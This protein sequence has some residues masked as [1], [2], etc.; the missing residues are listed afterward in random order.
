[1]GTLWDPVD[2]SRYPT[3]SLYGHCMANLWVIYGHFMGPCGQVEIPPPCSC[4]GNIWVID[5]QCMGN[6]WESHRLPINCPQITHTLPIQGKGGGISTCPQG[7]LTLSPMG[8]GY[9]LSPMGGAIM[10]P[11]S[12][13]A[14]NVGLD[15]KMVVLVCQKWYKLLNKPKFSPPEVMGR[16]H[17]HLVISCRFLLVANL[18]E[19]FPTG[20]DKIIIIFHRIIQLPQKSQEIRKT[21]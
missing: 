20:S 15:Q 8:S 4:I 18:Y 6:Q 1:M 14:T 16:S 2:N 7:P 13:M 5:G 11:L 10:P 21:K 9:P 19:S 17:C 3:F 12:K